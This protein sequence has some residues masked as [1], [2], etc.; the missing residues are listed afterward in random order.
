MKKIITAFVSAAC[1]MCAASVHAG[2]FKLDFQASNFR[3]QLT[4]GPAPVN[5]VTGSIV[6]TAAALGSP[7]T[8]ID[9]VDLTILGHAYSAVEVGVRH[10][11]GV[12]LL[13]FGGLTF[14]A[15]G[16]LSGTDDFFLRINPL[17]AAGYV[18]YTGVGKAGIWS[19][20]ITATFTELAAEVPEPGSLA[21]L[22][23]GAG[24]LG[25][26]RRRRRT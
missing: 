19:S 16:L 25:A 26:L 18:S 23:A 2:V 22:L 9:E 3:D 10:Y 12:D 7:V 17:T 24:S 13:D 15:T 5:G 6:F 20:Q 11:P 21:L 14:D 8:S 1:L 4:P